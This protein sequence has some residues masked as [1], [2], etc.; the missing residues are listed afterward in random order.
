M[1]WQ[2][3]TTRNILAIIT[4]VTFLGVIGF[5]IKN[6]VDLAENPITMMLLGQFSTVVALIYYFYFRKQQHAKETTDLD[7]E[8]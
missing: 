6:E 7:E 5:I 8:F 2:K 3:L 1:I 4:T